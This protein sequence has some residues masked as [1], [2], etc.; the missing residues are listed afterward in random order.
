[1]ANISIVDSDQ[2]NVD[3]IASVLK[4]ESH[5]LSFYTTAEALLASLNKKRADMIIIGVELEQG[6]GRNLS[7]FLQNE[8]PFKDIPVILTSPFYHT[9]GE[10][11]HYCCDDLVVMPLEPALLT[12]SVNKL[13]AKE[14]IK[15]SKLQAAAN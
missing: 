10:I 13:L 14:Q 2:E 4:S 12:V 5:K 6:D 11:R 7:K 1:M 8:S 9:E 15:A 3:S